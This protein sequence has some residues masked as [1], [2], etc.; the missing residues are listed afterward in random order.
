[1]L[2][3]LLGITAVPSLTGLDVR[4]SDTPDPTFLRAMRH[5]SALRDIPHA[6]SSACP[7]MPPSPSSASP[8]E[9]RPFRSPR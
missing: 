1:M 4:R 5:R 9:D 3:A 7:R 8:A 6:T 2:T